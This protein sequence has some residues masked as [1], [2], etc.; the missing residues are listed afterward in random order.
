MSTMTV[1]HSVSSASITAIFKSLLIP[2]FSNSRGFGPALYGAQ[3]AGQISS[4]VRSMLYFATILTPRWPS[5]I[6]SDCVFVSMIFSW[7]AL[8]LGQFWPLFSNHSSFVSHVHVQLSDNAWF[9]SAVPLL[10]CFVHRLPP[11]SVLVGPFVQGPRYTPVDLYAEQCTCARDVQQD[12]SGS[13]SPNIQNWTFA[14]TSCIS[15]RGSIGCAGLAFCPF[16]KSSVH[17]LTLW[18][19]PVI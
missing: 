13:S 6:D 18:R 5:G 3:C 4:D 14:Q 11:L 15:R 17:T 10:S 12:S 9:S 2:D 16:P 1:V 7:W 19:A 8:S